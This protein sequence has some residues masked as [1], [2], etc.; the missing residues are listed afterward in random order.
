MEVYDVNHQ[1]DQSK[2][3]NAGLG[4]PQA[5]SQITNI[6]LSEISN[7]TPLQCRVESARVTA[8]GSASL[9]QTYNFSLLVTTRSNPA[10]EFKMMS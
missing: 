3:A 5:I 9:L 10:R 1:C 7:P 4:M 8:E 2:R 6:K